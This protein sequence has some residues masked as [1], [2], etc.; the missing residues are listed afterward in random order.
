MNSVLKARKSYN[1]RM[2]FV[3]W[4]GFTREHDSWEPEENLKN[5]QDKIAEFYARNNK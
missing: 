1:K 4:E 5:T 3:R 2:F